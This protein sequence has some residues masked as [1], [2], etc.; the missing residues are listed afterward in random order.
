MCFGNASFLGDLSRYVTGT[1]DSASTVYTQYHE[2]YTKDLAI[3]SKTMIG[4]G[5]GVFTLLIPLIIMI[6]G[7]VV[8]RKRRT[9]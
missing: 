6:T 5:Y 9:L 1:T 7:I 8:Y 2:L 3:S 4:L